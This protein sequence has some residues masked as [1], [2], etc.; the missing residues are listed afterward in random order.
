MPRL[1]RLGAPGVLH[2]NMIKGIERRKIFLSNKDREDFL[3]RLETL[4]P[5]TKN[6]LLRMGI[7]AESCPFPFQN[8]QR[9]RYKAHEEAAYWV[10]CQF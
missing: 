10:C 2:H 1:A 8:R 5:E 3:E 4:L 7:Y 9:P 6:D